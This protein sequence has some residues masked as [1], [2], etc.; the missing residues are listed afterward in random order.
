VKF[1][2]LL[3]NPRYLAS[4]RKGQIS[5]GGCSSEILASKKEISLPINSGRQRYNFGQ[6]YK[7]DGFGMSTIILKK[8]IK[9]LAKINAT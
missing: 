9:S 1:L 8:L 4:P 6:N 5:P 3:N 2:I 7:W